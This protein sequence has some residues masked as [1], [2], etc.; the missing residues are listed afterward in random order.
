MNST[1]AN[2]AALA[3]RTLLAAMFLLA[4]YGKIGG[5]AGTVGYIG[6]VGLPAPQLLAA[7]A[8]VVELVGGA[9]LLIGWKARWAALALAGFTVLASVLFHN[10]WAMPAAQQMMQQLMFTKN[11]A[12]TGGLL[13][14]AAL[15]A[16]G[17]SVDRR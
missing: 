11:M 3:G 4:G 17:W 14:V 15:G 13:M 1:M 10:Y 12:V 7:A 5:F 8:V 6:S 2:A 9:L 16:G